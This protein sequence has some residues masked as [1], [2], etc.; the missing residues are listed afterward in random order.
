M[1]KN[2][3]IYK[4]QIYKAVVKYSLFLYVK[5]ASTKKSPVYRHHESGPANDVVQPTYIQDSLLSG[6]GKEGFIDIVDV[7]FVRPDQRDSYESL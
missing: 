3:L 7:S 4:K 1:K 2:T 6:G 5:V